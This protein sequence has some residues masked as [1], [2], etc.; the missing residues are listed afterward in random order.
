MDKYSENRTGMNI[1]ARPSE[2]NEVISN[3]AR[4][5]ENIIDKCNCI[6]TKITPVLRQVPTASS[7]DKVA[8]PL[9]SST[10]AQDINVQVNKLN[11]LSIHLDNIISKI[12][13]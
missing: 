1:P 5:T 13:L 3:L 6:E 10:L 7:Q 11:D 2:I 12:E 8:N 9:F 4:Q